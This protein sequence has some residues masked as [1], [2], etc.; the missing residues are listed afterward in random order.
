V[1]MT[2]REMDSCFRRNDMERDRNDRRETGM[3]PVFF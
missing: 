3:T 1:G 2:E